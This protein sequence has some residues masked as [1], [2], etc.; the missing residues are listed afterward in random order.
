MAD[1]L[2]NIK[3]ANSVKIG[4]DEHTFVNSDFFDITLDGIIVKI[5][6]KRSKRENNTS[7]MNAISW[8]Y[9][10]TEEPQRAKK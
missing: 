8:M 2:L 7:L 1:K 9:L 4:N 5:V 10:P 6:D 3:M